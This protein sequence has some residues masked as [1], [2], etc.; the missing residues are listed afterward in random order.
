MNQTLKE[1]LLVAR[2]AAEEAQDYRMVDHLSALI[3][4]EDF[5]RLRKPTRNG[6]TKRLRAVTSQESGDVSGRAITHLG[7]YADPISPIAG[8]VEEG[9]NPVSKGDLV[10]VVTHGAARTRYWNPSNTA[11]NDER[12]WSPPPLFLTPT[13][14]LEDAVRRLAD[15][16]LKEAADKGLY[17][18][19]SI[20]RH[21][22]DNPP[23]QKPD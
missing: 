23:E 6:E 7:E 18:P 15:R 9:A 4:G 19:D 12:S 11:E 5:V 1:C 2:D 22:L 21:F 8:V 3:E 10:W 13:P 17:T 20:E 14:M 16:V